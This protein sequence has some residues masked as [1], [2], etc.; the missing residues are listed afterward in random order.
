MYLFIPSLIHMNQLG[1]TLIECYRDKRERSNY[2]AVLTTNTSLS[3]TKFMTDD[4]SRIVLR[5]RLGQ[6]N[7]KLYISTDMVPSIARVLLS[8]SRSSNARRWDERWQRIAA[9]TDRKSPTELAA[10]A[11]SAERSRP[12]TIKMRV[13]LH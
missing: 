12:R 5:Q 8:A 11:R 2:D 13:V 10:L 7:H 3:I 1:K 9:Q 4:G 6:R